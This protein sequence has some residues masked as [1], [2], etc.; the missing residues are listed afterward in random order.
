MK[1]TSAELK[2]VVRLSAAAVTPFGFAALFGADEFLPRETVN[3]LGSFDWRYDVIEGSSR[4]KLIL[5]LLRRIEAGVLTRA[6]VDTE[7]WDRGW[8]ENLAALRNGEV[9]ALVPKYIRAGEPLRL[10]GDF[11]QPVDPA[12]HLNW[13][14]VLRDWFFRTYLA[15]FGEVY[16]FGCG[17]GHNLEAALAM[18]PQASVFGMDWSQP[19]VDIVYE[20]GRR[21]RRVAGF[22]FD[23]FAPDESFE[24][25]KNAVVLTAGA[26]EQTAD[27]WGPFLD[28]LL[29]KKPARVCH[30][31]PVLEWY[32]PDSLI[33]YT[34]IAAHRQR[35]YW[36]GFFGRLEELE[37]DGRVRILRQHRTRFGGLVVEGY[38]QIV[39][40]PV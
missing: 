35:R 30:L 12:F 11:V 28:F 15:G 29:R 32:D 25:G 7:R 16:E 8:A 2:Q 3:M 34:A 4:D 9:D 17:S 23:F 40:E 33:D 18:F 22:K 31:E 14:R 36:S 37:R 21:H 6:D 10:L 38:S 13:Y 26:L 24:F 39:W 5:D 27:R 1:F 20:L 19:A